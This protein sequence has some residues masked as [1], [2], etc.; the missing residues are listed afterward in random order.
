[1]QRYD[2]F[3]KYQEN[4][5]KY[6]F[7]MFIRSKQGILIYSEPFLHNLCIEGW[8]IHA[9]RLIEI[10]ELDQI[11][12]KWEQRRGLISEHLAHANPSN[13]LDPRPEKR[14]N[15]CWSIEDFYIELIKDI[16]KIANK[17]KSEFKYYDLLIDIL[18]S[19][20]NA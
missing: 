4:D 13:R 16:E 17:Y 9:R 10:F 14:A 2:K 5:L 19:A 15:P 1:M 8:L 20:K 11:D 6:E 18:N 3:L 12:K 7:E